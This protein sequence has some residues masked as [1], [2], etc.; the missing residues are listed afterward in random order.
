MRVDIPCRLGLGGAPLG[1]MTRAVPEEEAQETLQAAWEQGIRFFDTAPHYGTGLSEQRFGEFLSTRP[2]DE[3]FL[4][5][6]VGRLITDERVDLD[7]DDLFGQGLPYRKVFDYTEDGALRSIEDSLK[8]LKTD[9]LDMVWIHDVS[10]DV[11]GEDWGRQLDTA[12]DG[13][14]RALTRLREEGVIKGWGLGVNLVEPCLRALEHSDPDAFLQAG[15]Y[16]LLDHDRTL[17]ELYPRC[18]ERGVGIVQGG[19]FNSGL[20]AGGDLYEYAEA[21]QGKRDQAT[22]LRAIAERFDIDLRAAALQFV[23]AHPSVQATIPGTTRAERVAEYVALFEAEITGEFWQTLK[24]E[25]LLP[26]QA[27][28]PD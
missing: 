3:Y 22:R 7:P 15:R 20:L 10:E 25:G 16:T 23:V 14:A 8:R 13:A 17:N 19:P 1:N 28:V 26:E 6:K 12:L 2:R 4:T 24:H 27:P 11:H 9:R 21:P 5:T 18:L